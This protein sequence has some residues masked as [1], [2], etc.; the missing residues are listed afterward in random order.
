MSRSGVVDALMLSSPG[1]TGRSSNHCPADIGLTRSSR[2]MTLRIGLIHPM[3]I[4]SNFPLFAEL[5]ARL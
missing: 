1:L 4:D 3:K 5:A 2:A